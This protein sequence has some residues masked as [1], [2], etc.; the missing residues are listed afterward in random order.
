MVEQ[1][2]QPASSGKNTGM[3]ILCYIGILFI[4][5]LLT[6]AKD[7]PF[8]KYHIKQGLTL[9][10]FEVVLSIL[11][12]FLWFLAI[13]WWVIWILLFIVWIMGIINA[14]NGKQ[15][16]LPVIGKIGESFKF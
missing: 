16:P 14:A 10:I 2:S 3:A 8:V 9:F 15:E 12:G 4:V 7:D 5:P 1:T 13:L 6:D 11:S